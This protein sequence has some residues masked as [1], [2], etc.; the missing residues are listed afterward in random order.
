MTLPRTAIATIALIVGGFALAG[1]TT[2]QPNLALN[3]AQSA[4]EKA[5]ADPKISSLAL[6]EVEQSR[7]AL[8]TAQDLW[9]NNGNKVDVD[10]YA[11]VAKQRAAVAEQVTRMRLAQNETA[12]A[13]RVITL[14]DIQFGTG[15]STLTNEGQRAV[16]QLVSFM[17]DHPDRRAVITGN[18][19]STGSAK[20]NA[21]LA[22]ERAAAVQQAVAAAGIDP[23]RLET[24]AM[25]PSVPVASNAT[26]W[27][28]SENRRTEVALIST[29]P[30]EVGLSLAPDV[31]VAN[32]DATLTF[33]GGSVGLG[34]GFT[35][36][37]GTLDFN[38]KAYPIK[39]SGLGVGD[40][41]ASSI[42]AKATVH[43]LKFVDDIEGTY[44]VVKAGVTVGV[45]GSATAMRNEHGV[46]LQLLSSQAGLE[47]QFAPG[48]LTLALQ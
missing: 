27:G 3:D 20:T 2:P 18:T 42:D 24:A 45:G 46:M 25:G 38:G 36:G 22:V 43:N 4:Y 30:T 32:Q 48:G 37:Q 11:Y 47:F 7:E 41:G 40:V 14:A 10:H 33:A 19:D 28:R 17:R 15:K 44:S 23:A 21:R 5:T 35:W 26:A 29:L 39:L 6:N 31:P 8:K 9:S 1:C 16:N 12:N 34:V 13:T